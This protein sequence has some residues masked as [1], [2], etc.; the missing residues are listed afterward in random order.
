M[1]KSLHESPLYAG[2]D[3]GEI[4]RIVLEQPVKTFAAGELVI[5]EGAANDRI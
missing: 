3:P 5:A 2:L 4:D 1:S